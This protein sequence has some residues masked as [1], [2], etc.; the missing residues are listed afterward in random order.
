MAIRVAG[1]DPSDRIVLTTIEHAEESRG[2]DDKVSLED[3]INHL[4]ADYRNAVIING[5]IIHAVGWANGEFNED[6]VVDNVP[7]NIKDL[8]TI[9]KSL[10]SKKLASD[11]EDSPSMTVQELIAELQ[12]QDPSAEVG[13]SMKSRTG[14]VAKIDGVFITSDGIVVINQ[15]E[16]TMGEEEKDIL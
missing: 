5:H 8:Q 1:D 10:S 16:G 6:L 9:V 13:I 15:A 12:K 3:A 2:G 14:Y 11:G 7:T 4:E